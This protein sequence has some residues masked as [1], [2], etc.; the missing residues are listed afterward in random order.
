MAT[1]GGPFGRT[2]P[3]TI[4][5]INLTTYDLRHVGRNSRCSLGAPRR[6]G[7]EARSIALSNDTR[8]WTTARRACDLSPFGPPQ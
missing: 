8:T 4:D 2:A 6:Q 5:C 1:L 7:I 3:V